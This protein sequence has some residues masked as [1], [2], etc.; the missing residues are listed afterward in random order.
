M[1]DGPWS[2]NDTKVDVHGMLEPRGHRYSTLIL[3]IGWFSF[4]SMKLQETDLVLGIS[5]AEPGEILLDSGY[6]EY[7]LTDGI[8][9]SGGKS[10]QEDFVRGLSRRKRGKQGFPSWVGPGVISD[11]KSRTESKAD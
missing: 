7:R 8:M 5:A 9:E 11:R 2:R 6:R 1:M 4:C 3:A 10:G